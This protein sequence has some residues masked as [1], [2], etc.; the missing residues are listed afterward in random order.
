MTLLFNYSFYS[1][2]EIQYKHI[3]IIKFVMNF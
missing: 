2:E 3:V 1:S